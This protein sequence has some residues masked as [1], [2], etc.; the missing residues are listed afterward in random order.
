[1]CVIHFSGYFLGGNDHWET[2]LNG[3]LPFKLPFT[4][5]E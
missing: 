5:G 2:P 1:M 3:V 4:L